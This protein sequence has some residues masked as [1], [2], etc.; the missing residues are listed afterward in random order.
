MAARP[1]DA[2][3]SQRG[4]TNPS[5][6]EAVVGAPQS[7]KVRVERQRSGLPSRRH[8]RYAK[9]QQKVYQPGG[10][11]RVKVRR[12]LRHWW[13]A[14][15]SLEVLRWIREG[16][17]LEWETGQAPPRFHQGCS[18]TGCTPEERAFVKEETERLLS[19]GAVRV[20]RPGLPRS[21]I[22]RQVPYDLGWAHGSS[23]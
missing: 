16:V 8:Y 13:S 5:A 12:K 15:A 11:L 23:N 20:A 17:R 1:E 9:V 6:A 2:A 19:S 3:A 7:G 22:Q 4:T 14:G 21:E 18:F 10:G